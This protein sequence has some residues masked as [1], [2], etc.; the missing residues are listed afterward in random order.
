MLK[1]GLLS[2]LFSWLLP[3]RRWRHAFRNYCRNQDTCR[4]IQWIQKRHSKLIKKLQNQY[5]KR[6]IKVVFLNS[7]IA[8][9]V[10]G[11][12]YEIL[13]NSPNY[14]VQVLI[15]VGTNLLKNAF[16]FLDYERLARRDYNKFK[17][18][19]F[20]VS[21][22]FDFTKR[23]YKSLKTF[24]PDIIFYEQPWDLAKEHA[25]FKTA[26][27]ALAL[28]CSYGSCITNG[29][30][31]YSALFY[32]EVYAYFL[33]NYEIKAKLLN[34]S[35]EEH[36]LVVAGHL[37]LDHYLI[38]INHHNILWRTKNKKRIIYAPH[39]AFDQDSIL[40][41]GTFDWNY[42]FFYDFAKAHPEIEFILKPHPR[43][44]KSIV[45]SQLM[46]VEEMQAYFRRWEQLPN[47]RI[48][49]LNNYF[50]MFR[51]SDLLITDCN[52]FLYEYL[53]T[54]KPVLRLINQN[55][56]GHN[57]FGNAIIAGY[58]QANDLKEIQYYLDLILLQNQDP[59]FSVRK[60]IVNNKLIQPQKGTANYI[61]NYLERLLG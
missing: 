3:S 46:S 60:A 50:D 49:E 40:K 2:S 21:Y 61:F 55:S 43:L 36:R 41:F 35:F 28:Y 44:K 31:E 37:K 6:K 23:K 57:A 16:G 47:A 52:S 48:Y 18:D 29:V 34:L 12:L 19:G 27:Y 14:E 26:K 24:K 1:Y 10:Y 25:I 56:V 45:T 54:L 4:Q 38:P 30:N 42:R 5:G 58:Y 32:R 39:H 17:A 8:K 53:P 7:E 20:N 33:D 59:L 51:T 9:W 11:P 22:A 13:K 15:T